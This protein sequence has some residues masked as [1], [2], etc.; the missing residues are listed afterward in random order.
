MRAAIRRG[1]QIVVDDW[2][3]PPIEDGQVRVRTLH[4]GI[5]GSDLHAVHNFESFIEYGR[6]AQLLTGRID[7]T[8]DV[9]FGH[10]FCA[11]IVEFGPGTQKAVKEGAAVC[12][13][14]V[15][16]DKQGAEGV[17]FSNRYPGGYAE[18]MILTESMLL[19]VTNG[20][21]SEQAALVEPMAVAVHAVNKADLIDSAY[22]VVGCGPIGLAIVAELKSRGLGPLVAVDFVP[23]RRRIAEL[24]GA[25]IV[26]DPAEFDPHSHWTAFEV[27]H[28][29]L[30]Y[31]RVQTKSRRAVI[32]ECV[33]VPG[34]LNK[35][36]DA[37]PRS[38][39]IIVAGVCMAPDTI[40]PSLAINKELELKF[41]MAYSTEEFRQTMG[42]VCEGELDVTPMISKI[43]GLDTVP[44]TFDELLTNPRD[45]K[46]LVN[47]RI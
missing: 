41:V 18:Y 47:P 12:A 15:N 27:P 34:I 24:L 29:L 40:E 5:C 35:L 10:E 37:A 33:G 22:M 30:V 28:G 4:C 19:P 36:V 13:F 39:Q 8:K 38:A 23:E 31:P 2:E 14:A 11:Q 46:V 32:F 1:Q 26:V 16:F 42:R 45:A 21:P 17:G 20:C 7:P 44:A 3:L 25:D 9:V 6:R 43:I